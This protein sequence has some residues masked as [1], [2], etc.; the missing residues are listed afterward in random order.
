MD[1]VIITGA[2]G[3]IGSSLTNYLAEKG[4]TI[5]AVVRNEYSN[6]D[7][8][9]KH[10]NIRIIYCDLQDAEKLE[11]LIVDRDIDV[12]Y[13]LA[14][15][16]ASGPKRA[17]YKIQMDN[18]S[19]S[20][21]CARQAKLMG[22]G[23]FIAIGTIGEFMAELALKNNIVS[24]NFTYAISKNYY[25]SLLDIYCYHNNISYTW[26]TLSGVYGIGD[27]TSNIINYTIKK[28]LL[29]EL[30]EYT[31]AEQLFDFVYI[32]DCVK[33]MYEI[34][35]KNDSKKY[36]FIG[37]PSPQ[38]LKT[39]I[40]KVRDVISPDSHIGLGRRN[41]DGIIYKEEWFTMDETIKHLDFSHEYTFEDGIKLTTEWLK[42]TISG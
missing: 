13:H 6:V 36:Y 26:C 38:P 28:I 39:F 16:G 14:W 34:G 23:R 41:E 40:K 5:F 29:K 21:E 31:K 8:I 12:F 9:M 1:K 27:S 2:N 11:H 7:T 24:E 37:G 20:L 3:F 22:C 35:L 30:P 33:C 32:D 42:S 17:D 10:E 15:T 18:V 25:H 19:N 4:V